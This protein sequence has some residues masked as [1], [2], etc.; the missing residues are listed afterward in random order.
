MKILKLEQPGCKP[1]KDVAVFL[2]N[3][4]V[5]HEVVDVTVKPEVASKYGV[6][7]LPVIILLDNDEVEVAR[8]IGY[9]PHELEELI[10]N[11]K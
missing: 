10:E 1:C 4:N 6:M 9:K 7:S 8:S 5:P 3:N 11:L 2:A